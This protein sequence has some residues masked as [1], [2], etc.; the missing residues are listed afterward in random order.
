MKKGS[1]NKEDIHMYSKEDGEIK[2]GYPAI[3]IEI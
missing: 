3:K 2:E 1:R